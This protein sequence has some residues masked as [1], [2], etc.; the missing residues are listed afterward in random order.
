MTYIETPNEEF[1]VCLSGPIP[2]GLSSEEKKV[3][4]GI[5]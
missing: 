4:G 1:V 2:V 5:P 3:G